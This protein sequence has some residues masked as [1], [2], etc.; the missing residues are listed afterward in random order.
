MLSVNITSDID[1][2]LGE[3][4]KTFEDQIPFAMSQAV[5]DT[6]FQARNKVVQST[7]PEAFDV[8]NA[9]FPG[10]LFKITDE[11]GGVYRG[12]AREFAKQL[13]GTGTAS[14]YLSDTMGHDYIE[15]HTSG[16]TKTP[17]GTNIAIPSEP[18]SVRGPSGRVLSPNKPLNVTKKKKVFLLERNGRKIGIM[19]RKENNRLKTIYNF[20]KSANI[21]KA[22]N[23]Y[24]DVDL[25]A[26]SSFF[27]LFDERMARIITRSR[28]YPK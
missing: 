14:V 15:D 10:V 4:K 19:E 17:Q 12:G 6:A 16:G 5:L 1:L 8:K 20:V 7:W 22:F 9:R 24:E 3:I 28:F 18:G 25:V 21:D 27:R 2:S 11:G 26:D 23:F 13:R